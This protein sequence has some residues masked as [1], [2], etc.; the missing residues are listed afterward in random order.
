M[1][2]ARGTTLIEVMVAIA[3]LGIGVGVAAG[4]L[5]GESVFTA[6]A[7]ERRL[8]SLALQ[9]EAEL[10]RRVPAR[11]LAKGERA[12][13]C[14]DCLSRLRAA[15]GTVTPRALGGGAVE[16]KLRVEWTRPGGARES[17]EL[18]TLRAPWKEGR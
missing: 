10:L 6:A 4:A 15:R 18:S 1:K 13:S 17:A 14:A 9:E 7:A 12:F 5:R 3:T 8:A 16:L 11:E 2:P